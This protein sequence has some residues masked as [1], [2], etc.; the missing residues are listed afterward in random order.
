MLREDYLVTGRGVHS[1]TESG[2]KVRYVTEGKGGPVRQKE[3]RRLRRV[4]KV[5]SDARKLSSMAAGAA[6]KRALRQ[7]AFTGRAIEPSSVE[8]MAAIYRARF[9]A[10]YA[11][12]AG[13]IPDLSKL[14]L[15]RKSI[16]R[17]VVCPKVAEVRWQMDAAGLLKAADDWTERQAQ[18]E[19]AGQS[20]ERGKKI[21]VVLSVHDTARNPYPF[22]VRLAWVRAVWGASKASIAEAYRGHRDLARVVSS[23][24][25]RG[26]AASLGN[27]EAAEAEREDLERVALLREETTAKAVE[28]YGSGD[29]GA[30]RLDVRRHVQHAR[31]CLLAFHLMD[32]KRQW[33]SELAQDMGRL[34]KLAR[35]VRGESFA[36]LGDWVGEFN[37]SSKRKEFERFQKRLGAGDLILS[38]S[39]ADKAEETI[40][41]YERVRA[42]GRKKSAL[43]VMVD[44]NGNLTSDALTI[45]SAKGRLHVAT[46]ATVRGLVREEKA[47]AAK[48]KARLA[49]RRAVVCGSVAILPAPAVPAESFTPFA[50]LPWSDEAEAGKAGRVMRERVR[51][52][53]KLHALYRDGFRYGGGVIAL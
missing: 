30:R 20:K 41:A 25:L 8:E 16:V 3:A 1:Y 38:G 6:H 21:N 17:V 44:G 7:E 34:A 2:R 24:E 46:V 50:L 4:R 39:K 53:R 12:S 32:G 19:A 9:S 15:R 42:N 48:A 22:R 51:K 52:G 18:R 29:R 26:L 37:G 33:Q 14:F 5:A 10:A 45:E 13:I 27:T 23:D 11:A 47:E 43:R 36:L 31:R 40:A 35:I 49:A 28:T